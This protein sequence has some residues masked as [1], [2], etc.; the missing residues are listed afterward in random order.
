M[1]EEKRDTQKKRITLFYVQLIRTNVAY[2][3]LCVTLE[4]EKCYECKVFLICLTLGAE[5]GKECKAFLD[6]R[7]VVRTEC[8]AFL[9][10]HNTR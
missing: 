6:L 10:L 8:K 1:R 9:H 5:N 7:A 2:W 4:C 3:R